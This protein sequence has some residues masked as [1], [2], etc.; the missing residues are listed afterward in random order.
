MTT[1][2][3]DR[4]KYIA[5]RLEVGGIVVVLETV[6]IVHVCDEKENQ[7]KV[8]I[9]GIPAIA[10]N[11]NCCSIHVVD[12]DTGETVFKCEIQKFAYA[13]ASEHFHVFEADDERCYGLTFV[14]P[15]VGKKVMA[16]VE[17][18]SAC[19]LTDEVDGTLKRTKKGVEISHPTDF[20]HHSHV[21]TNTPISTLV[22]ALSGESV[23]PSVE[24]IPTSC[25][26]VFQ[27]PLAQHTTS[28]QPTET[29]TPVNIVPVV[30]DATPPPPPVPQGA[31]PPPPPPP[32]PIKPPPP[33]LQ[34]PLR[35]RMRTLPAAPPAVDQGAL[36]SELA[37]FSRST[38]RRVNKDTISQ[39]SNMPDSAA[40]TDLSKILK[41]SLDRMRPKLQS[42]LAAAAVV[43]VCSDGTES[44]KDD[45]DGVLFV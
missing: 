17:Q 2:V 31:P 39:S 13:Y 4:Q 12:L 34:L 1:P 24:T 5:S 33:P 9:C 10:A 36:I 20:R 32:P 28:P 27:Q 41:S 18:L 25:E 35:G 15:V 22:A 11:N 21:S 8:I 3:A 26:P 7:W 37:K 6:A 44:G 43:T 14:D 30:Q 42:E 19:T 29:V 40:E 23:S 16:A 38:L 45:F